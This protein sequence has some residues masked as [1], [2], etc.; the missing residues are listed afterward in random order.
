MIA[1]HSALLWFAAGLGLTIL[2]TFFAPL[3]NTLGANAR[4]VYF[5]GVWVWVAMLAFGA[6][7]LI[8]LAA[9]I[10]RRTILH[11]WSRALGW[12]GLFFWI[13][14][15]G[16]SL[17]VMQLN[18]NGIFVDE[19]RFRIPL[20]FAIVGLL[21]QVG[22]TFLPD[23]RWTSLG[24]LGFGVA[25]LLG[26][27]GVDTVLHPDSPIFNSEARSIQ[28]FFLLLLILQTGVAW[29]LAR[30]LIKRQQPHTGDAA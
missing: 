30:W 9:L 3:E 13:T 27:G 6:A 22:L 28:I 25:L 1:K 11:H 19:P 14:F 18:W 4:L 8:G 15:L 24:N 2:F 16:M 17:V 26:M 29:L 12:T 5:H 21:L 10:S 7:A 23:L 20:N